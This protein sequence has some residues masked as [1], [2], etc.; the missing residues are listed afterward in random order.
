MD[1]RDL[2]VPGALIA[3]RVTPQARRASITRDDSGQLRISV[4]VA[5]EKGRANDAVRRMLAK[6]LGV[7][8]SRL[9]L[10]RGQTGRD[11]QFRLNG[12]D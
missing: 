5:A 8:P 4:T 11:K 6:A 12:A 9:T 10:L 1:L 2:A 3:V 7:A